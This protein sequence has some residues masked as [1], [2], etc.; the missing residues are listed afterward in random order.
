MTMMIYRSAETCWAAASGRRRSLPGRIIR[1][2]CHEH[3]GD[4]YD[5][6][7]DGDDDDG[8]SDDGDGVQKQQGVPPT[9]FFPRVTSPGRRGPTGAIFEIVLQKIYQRKAQRSYRIFLY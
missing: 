1:F 4:D 7:G 6:D 3:D 9:K 2:F 8:N 5:G